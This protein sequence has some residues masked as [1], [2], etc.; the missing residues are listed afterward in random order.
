M[1]DARRLFG[2]DEPVSERILV[3]AGRLSAT[4]EAGNLRHVRFDGIEIIRAISCVVRDHEWGTAAPVIEDFRVDEHGDRFRL[5]YG[6]VCRIGTQCVR[7][8]AE[9]DGRERA[10]DF[11]IRARAET[12]FLTSRLGFVVLHPIGGVAGEP[13]EILHVDGSVERARF[14][15]LIEP[16]QPFRDIRALTHAPCAGLTVTCRMEGDTFETEDQRNWTDASYKTYVRPLGLPW[17][18][19]LDA[20]TELEQSVTLRIEGEPESGRADDTPPTLTLGRPAGRLPAIGLHLEPGR[21]PSPRAISQ[22]RELRPG[23]LLARHDGRTRDLEALRRASALAAA[24]DAALHLEV[25]LPGDDVEAEAGALARDIA[26]TG[27]VVDTV[28]VFPAADLK[29]TLP[30]REWPACPPLTDVYRALRSALPA[31]RLVGG[32]PHFFTELNRKRPPAAF[33]DAVTFSTS[34]IVHA[35]DDTTVIENLETLPAIFRSAEAIAEGQE[36]YLGPSHIA[37]RDNPYGEAASPNP[38]RVRKAMTDDDP[39]QLGHFAAA[40]TVGFLARCIGTAVCHATLGSPV[41]RFGILHDDIDIPGDQDLARPVYDVLRTVGRAGRAHAI[42]VAS[43]APNR[44]AAV[45][46]RENEATRLLLAN[47][48]ADPSEV[49]VANGRDRGTLSLAPFETREVT[50]PV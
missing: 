24:L 11:R 28:L 21:M 25:V 19:R 34:A 22:L 3:R 38:D 5:S 39:R 50:L 27:A 44:V 8:D 6:A 40:W 10:I 14:P 18:Y 12:D 13:V 47:L 41:G 4:L 20:G 31:V 37:C 9:I 32:T 7:Y 43:T 16:Y 17:P 46:W 49:I 26:E 30:G 2:T 45:A 23:F 35:A 36:I 15:D 1:N 42:A 33:L 29:G 48:T